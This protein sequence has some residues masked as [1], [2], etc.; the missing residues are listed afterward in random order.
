MK[1]NFC[2]SDIDSFQF[3]QEIEAERSW[4]KTLK[5]EDKEIAEIFFD[6]DLFGSKVKELEEDYIEIKQEIKNKLIYLKKHSKNKEEVEILR[7]F[8]IQSSMIELIETEK[9]IK[10]LQRLTN[11]K[12]GYEIKNKNGVTKDDIDKVKQVPLLQIASEFTKLRKC[13]RNYIGLCPLHKERTPSFYIN[14]ET[15]T[16]HCFGAC[17]KHGDIINF[18]QETHRLSFIEAVK[19]LLNY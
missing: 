12:K 13:G 10:Y 1:T 4:G 7:I 6:K 8:I 9:Q 5:L 16:Y 19:L 15:N 11:L 17:Q 18:I 2:N 3:H 14:P